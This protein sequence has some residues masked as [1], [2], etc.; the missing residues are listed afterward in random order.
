MKKLLLF[1]CAIVTSVAVQAQLQTPAPSPFQKIEQKVGLTDVTLEYSRPSM[2]GRTIFGG[3]VPYDNVWRTGANA[4]TKITFSDDVIIGGKTVKAGSYAIYTKPGMQSWDV[5]FYTD[6]NNW[7]TP[8]KWDESKVAATVKAQVY[9]MPMAIETFTMTFDDVA[10][11]SANL[12]ILWD[13]TY[14]G[15]PIKFETDKMVSASI[16][17]VMN[18][19]GANE[20]YQAAVYYLESGKDINKAKTWIDKAIEMRAEPAFW[21]HRQQS[22]IYAKAGD[23]KGAINAAKKSLSLAQEAGNDDYVALNTKSLKEWGAM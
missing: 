4:N 13:K 18:G 17:K 1:I 8:Q 11:D 22:L 21:Y 12:G 14:V 6:S 19:P 15:V 20:Y 16:D 23:K 7:G 3:L 2:K 10:S 9:P 5:M